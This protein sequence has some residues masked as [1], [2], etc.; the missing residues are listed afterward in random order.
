ML[1]KNK[2]VIFKKGHRPIWIKTHLSTSHVAAFPMVQLP[3]F[4]HKVTFRRTVPGRGG[5]TALPG[6]GAVLQSTMGRRPGF[7]RRATQQRARCAVK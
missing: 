2:T 6:T 7:A 4:E 3:S 1:E 5:T